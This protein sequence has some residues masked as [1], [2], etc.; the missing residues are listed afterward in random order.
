MIKFHLDTNSSYQLRL[1]NI[2]Q[3]A[4]VMALAE[5]FV[6]YDRSRPPEQQTPVTDRLADL[7]SQ[8]EPVAADQLKGEQ[9]RTAA[10]EAVKRLEREAEA[11]VDS[12]WH[13]MHSLYKQTPERA[14]AWGFDIRQ[15]SG[16]ILKPAS[17]QAR[18][19][20]LSRYVAQEENRPEAEQFSNPALSEVRRVRDELVAKLA[21][22]DAG[23]TRREDS[24]VAGQAFAKEMLNYLQVGLIYLMSEEFNFTLGPGLQNWGFTVVLGRNGHNHGRGNGNGHSSGT[25]GDLG[26]GGG[27]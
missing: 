12:I 5:Q 7:L 13:L 2:R 17:R 10:S 25:N 8:A 14:E 9:Q 15:G 18:L 24:L 27:I 1:P 22:R 20:L 11:L 6:A 19:A 4:K 23:K 21:T 3:R 26:N 16:R